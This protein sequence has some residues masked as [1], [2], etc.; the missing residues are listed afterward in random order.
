MKAIKIIITVL[1]VSVALAFAGRADWAETV[2]MSMPN[3]AYEAI[4]VKL[5][6]GASDYEIATEYINNREYYDGLSY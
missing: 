2:V 1:F 3:E 6:N 4:C 5:P